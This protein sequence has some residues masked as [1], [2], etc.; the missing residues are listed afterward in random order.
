MR[1]VFLDPAWHTLFLKFP[2]RSMYDTDTWVESRWG[3]LPLL[4]STARGW[5]AELPSDVA[6]RIEYR[7]FETLFGK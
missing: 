2:D 7:N 4:V 6:D 3:E 1:A 5:L